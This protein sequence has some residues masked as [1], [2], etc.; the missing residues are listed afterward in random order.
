MLWGSQSSF[1][2]NRLSRS[3][4]SAARAATAGAAWIP[5]AV[6]IAIAIAASLLWLDR[7]SGIAGVDDPSL[8]DRAD[9]LALLAYPLVGALLL[10]RGNAFGWPLALVG[11]LD[12]FEFFGQ[13]YALRGLY[14]KPGSL[15]LAR[16]GDLVAE[17][18]FVP[19][20]GWS[21]VLLPLLFPA[22]AP[23][24]RLWRL[25]AALSVITL[26][27]A[28]VSSVL[29]PGPIDEDRPSVRNPLGL[30]P[31]GALLDTIQVVS[32]LLLPP[33]L[34]AAFASLVVRWR[35]APEYGRYFALFG[36]AVVGLIVVIALDNPL[37]GRVPGWSLG[38]PLLTLWL[39]PLAAWLGGR[40]AG[41]QSRPRLLARRPRKSA[42]PDQ[43]TH[44]PSS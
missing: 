38:A 15:P 30:E 2:A 9:S 44:G 33:L 8:E 26:A 31:A 19:T 17:S 12:Q 3:H 4:R 29:S 10:H 6:S 16:V 22:G 7:P 25:V 23:L 37:Q 5:C 40:P 21:L 36:G 43:L 41:S 20:L 11:P 18:L 34:I 14:V 13:E 32:F 39:I 35:R 27:S 42:E 1:A 24:S 28:F